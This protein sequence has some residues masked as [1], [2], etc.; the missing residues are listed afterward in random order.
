MSL[1][2]WRSPGAHL[3]AW[4]GSLTT[5]ASPQTDST[6]TL[7]RQEGKGAEGRRDF[8][9]Q[10]PW[11]RRGVR[12]AKAP[13]PGPVPWPRHGEVDEGG[14]RRWMKEVDEGGRSQS[15]MPRSAVYRHKG[16]SVQRPRGARHA[17]REAKRH[18][19]VV[20]VVVNNDADTLSRR[21][22]QKK[23]TTLQYLPHATAPSHAVLASRAPYA[24]PPPSLG[25][26]STTDSG[27]A[28]QKGNWVTASDVRRAMLL[29]DGATTK[30]RWLRTQG[31]RRGRSPRGSLH[32][33]TMLPRLRDMHAC[34]GGTGHD[35][36]EAFFPSRGQLFFRVSV[37]V[38]VDVS[39]LVSSWRDAHNGSPPSSLGE[40]TALTHV[41]IWDPMQARQQ[42]RHHEII[43]LAATAYDFSPLPIVAQLAREGTLP[44]CAALHCN[45]KRMNDPIVRCSFLPTDGAP[46]VTDTD[47][48][49]LHLLCLCLFL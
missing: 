42:Q 38:I 2:T 24:P 34:P 44:R 22:T 30:T 11:Y 32:M 28:Q 6:T 12:G 33:L 41:F 3:D 49:I 29:G 37:S 26:A 13:P 17:V 47:T 45:G 21:A 48:Y 10:I 14:G 16:T 25:R 43:P 46:L 39:I 27:D 5:P 1:L 4:G 23:Q 19:V 9:L 8:L 7:R 15:Q 31:D 18:V 36:H 40:V 35:D 20:V